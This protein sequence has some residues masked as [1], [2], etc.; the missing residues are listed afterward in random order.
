MNKSLN[1][2]AMVSILVSFNACSVADQKVSLHPTLDVKSENVGKNM[3]V[4]VQILDERPEQNLGYR[5]TDESGKGAV[6]TTDQEVAEVFS[7]KIKEGLKKK[8]FEPISYSDDIARTLKI[9]IHALENNASDGFWTGDVRT[10]ASLKAVAQHS[11]EKYEKSYRTE[12]EE[13]IILV[14]LTEDNEQSINATI[15]EVLQITFEDQEL[16]EFLSN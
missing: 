5:G 3:Q 15:S 11:G 4:G 7:E 2:I 1:F 14:P 12:C 9:E 6:I 13:S 8:G 10:Q 16:F